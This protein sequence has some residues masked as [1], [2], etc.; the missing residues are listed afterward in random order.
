MMWL[1]A[2][3]ISLEGLFGGATHFHPP[4]VLSCLNSRD[5]LTDA[6]RKIKHSYANIIIIIISLGSMCVGGGDRRVENLDISISTASFPPSEEV[7]VRYLLGGQSTR[8]FSFLSLYQSIYLFPPSPV[9]LSRCIPCLAKSKQASRCG[10]KCLQLVNPRENMQLFFD[11][12]LLDP[13]IIADSCRATSERC[14][15]TEWNA[16]KSRGGSI[17]PADPESERSLECAAWE[18]AL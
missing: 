1:A 6:V 18:M 13:R 12:R 10:A 11:A 9:C 4:L 5:C 16:F 17:L 8:G 15:E 7:E 14:T 2:R 3:I